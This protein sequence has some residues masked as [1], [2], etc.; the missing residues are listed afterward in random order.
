MSPEKMQ[1]RLGHCVCKF[2]GGDLEIKV[3]IYNKYGGQGLEM[4]C[5]NCQKIEY[6]T[7]KGIYR[8]AKDFVE[9]VE[10]DYFPDMEEGKRS[11]ELNVAKACEVLSWGLR[12][13]EVMD[14]KGIKEN[15][16][17]NFDYEER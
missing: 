8:L 11:F 2:C 16:V 15:P 4:Y 17:C 1:E 10:F 14:E 3:I 6:G 12:R 9:N 13:L 5:P 7:E